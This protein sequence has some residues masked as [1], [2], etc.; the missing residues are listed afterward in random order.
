SSIGGSVLGICLVSAI[1]KQRVTVLR[2]GQGT[3]AMP[4]VEDLE[5]HDPLRLARGRARTRVRGNSILRVRHG[6]SPA[7]WSAGMRS[8][9]SSKR[10]AY[11]KA[12]SRTHSD[13]TTTA[14]QPRKP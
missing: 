12:A 4:N 3:E 6:Y 14:I 2:D 13:R 10:C 5:K 9:A 7:T 11:K 8:T 1:K